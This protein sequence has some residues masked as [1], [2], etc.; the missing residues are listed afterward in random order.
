[1]SFSFWLTSLNMI[2][3]YAHPYCCKWHYFIIFYSWVV[4]DGQGGLAFCDSWGC[5]ESKTTER[6]NWTKLNHLAVSSPLSLYLGIFLVGSNI[7]LSMFVLQWVV[8]LYFSQEK[9]GAYPSTPSSCLGVQN[10]KYDWKTN[11]S[12]HS[13]DSVVMSPPA[14][15]RS[16][17]SAN[18]ISVRNFSWKRKCLLTLLFLTRKS[19]EQRILVGYSPWCH[20][21]S[22]TT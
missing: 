10:V 9:M 1:M 21:E 7:L 22:G 2:N 13:G 3:L 8:I 16:T 20:K 17:G 5:K 4:G 15:E 12:L 6:L 19:K 18:F 11:T 14:K